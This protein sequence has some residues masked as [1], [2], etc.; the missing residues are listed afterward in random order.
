MTQITTPDLNKIL[1]ALRAVR[2]PS[3]NLQGIVISLF[4]PHF[5]YCGPP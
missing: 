3:V 2:D 1:E 4:V 5:Q